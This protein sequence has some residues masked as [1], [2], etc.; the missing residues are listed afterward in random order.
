M[1]DIFEGVD[2]PCDGCLWR[3]TGDI[4]DNYA[5]MLSIAK[6]NMAL[7]RYAGPGHW[8]DP[9]SGLLTTADP[10]AALSADVAGAGVVRL[11]VTDG[12]D[13]NNSDHADWA[14]AKLTCA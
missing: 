8:N 7:N 14:D 13:G 3:T 2:H 5:S 1:V 12:G 11:I 9:D 10:A 6:A 4:S